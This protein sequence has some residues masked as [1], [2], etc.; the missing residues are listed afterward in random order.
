MPIPN[1]LATENSRYEQLIANDLADFKT[2]DDDVYIVAYAKSGHHWSYDFINM[3]LK[4]NFELDNRIKEAVFVEFLLPVTDG[5]EAFDRLPS[6]RTIYTHFHA[7]ALPREVFSKK[8]KIVRLIRNPKDVAVSAFYHR[9][10]FTQSTNKLSQWDHYIEAL[11]NMIEGKETHDEAFLVN[12][13]DWFTYELDSEEKLNHL[14]HSLVLYY[15][16]LKEDMIPQLKKLAKFLGKE[17]DDE[18]YVKV[19][20]KTNLSYVKKNKDLGMHDAIVVGGS[21]YRK[22]VIGDWKNHF[23]SEQAKRF[24]E[25]IERR[26]KGCPFMENIRY[27]PMD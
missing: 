4:G 9:N 26:M 14:D 17:Y 10:S 5:M 19:A 25:I 24:D 11:M 21:L 3:L 15:E 2:R 13:G 20:A 7:D 27:E 1:F 16:D 12:K 18:F 22:G 8:R 6:P 23:S